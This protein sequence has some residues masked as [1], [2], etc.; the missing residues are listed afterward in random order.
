MD[1]EE[2]FD[3]SDEDWARRWQLEV[4]A[5]R[6]EL[7]KFQQEGRY[8][9]RQF[10]DLRTYDNQAEANDDE[11]TRWNLFSANVK[12]QLAL[13]YGKTPSVG[14][15]RTFGDAGD[16]IARVAGIMLER[17]LSCDLARSGDGYAPSIGYV[18]QDLLIPGLGIARERYTAEFEKR[19]VE[20][21]TAKHPDGSDV[22]DEATGAVVVQAEA[23]EE[24]VKTW[25]DSETDYIHWDDVLWSAGAR[26]HSE[27]RWLGFRSQM[28]RKELRK[29]FTKPVVPLED[30]TPS[31][32]VSPGTEKRKVQTVGDIVPLNSK[33]PSIPEDRKADP[34][35]R[36]DVWE[37][38]DK[39]H[40]E[41]F[42][43]VEGFD[44]ILDRVKDPLGLDGFFPA[45]EPLASNLTTDSCVPRNDYH[46]AKDLYGQINSYSSR[47][48]SLVDALKQVALYDKR[49]GV[50]F[51]RL[52]GQPGP[53]MIPVDNWSMFAE[54]GGIRGQIDF[55]PIDQVAATLDKLRDVRSE[56]M[57]VLFQI[58]GWSDLQRGQQLENGTPGE[59][60]VKAR[61][62]S[63]RMQA[64]QDRIARFASDLL[65]I[66][67]EIIC[68]HFDP[69]TIVARS[70]ILNTPD[71]EH[72]EEAVAFLKSRFSDYRIEVKPESMDLT[73]FLAMKQERT[74]LVMTL[75]SFFQ[76]ATPIAASLPNSMPFLLEIA[77]WLFASVRGGQTIEGVL[78]R[79]IAQAQQVASQPQQPQAQPPN[80]KLLELQMK[81]SMEQQK[82]QA[83]LQA[84]LARIRAET[85]AKGQQE[86]QQAF[87]NIAEARAKHAIARNGAQPAA[88]PGTFGGV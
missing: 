76:A 26:V 39:E 52:L 83:D 84:D 2:Q 8:A 87:A 79:A 46:L 78:D 23:Y 16:D 19:T 28:T 50:D 30:E 6:K 48:S 72:A 36:A 61:F 69:Q 54:K 47:I 56:L 55:F 17:N 75:A 34:W 57:A 77:K 22:L 7:E 86:Q 51:D 71:A 13:M 62:A 81:A 49:M 85:E 63:V 18:L 67:A 25:E 66:K 1:T 4:T 29:R 32:Q 3:D 33:R 65:R 21:I 37:I 82:T 43:W 9:I 88:L 53:I 31:T 38:W 15:S 73:D 42:W 35:Q 74:D 80:P 70:N 12:Q 20:A 10:R 14:V 64:L 24:E 44:R 40:R 27:R 41:V 68:K 59:A 45:P 58:T 60:A 5:S 11:D